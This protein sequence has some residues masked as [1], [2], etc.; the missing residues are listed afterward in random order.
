MHLRWRSGEAAAITLAGTAS[1]GPASH[2]AFAF[3]W[4]AGYRYPRYARVAVMAALAEVFAGRACCWPG[5]QVG[6]PLS[7]LPALFAIF[8]HC[9]PYCG[10]AGSPISTTGCWI[11]ARRCGLPGVGEL[12]TRHPV[13]RPATRGAWAVERTRWPGWRASRCGWPAAPGR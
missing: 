9:S 11:R 3:G 8:Q 2:L 10:E 13:L 7:V 5:G 6:D 1:T 4:L 12:M